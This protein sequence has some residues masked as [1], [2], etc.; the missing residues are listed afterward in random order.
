MNQSNYLEFV[1]IHARLSRFLMSLNRSKS[2]SFPTDG[3]T[4]IQRAPKILRL[5]F[6]TRSIIMG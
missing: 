1:L 5:E 4:K 3:Q 2:D 6:Y